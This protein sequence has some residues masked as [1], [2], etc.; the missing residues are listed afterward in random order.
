MENNQK[1]EEHSAPSETPLSEPQASTD[2]VAPTPNPAP[3]NPEPAAHKNSAG[4][5][6]LQWLTYAFWGWSILSSYILVWTLSSYFIGDNSGLGE[7]TA[8]VVAAALVLLPVAFVTDLFY[9]RIEPAKKTG[10][11]SIVMV[12]HAV[13]FA[14]FAIGNLIGAIFAVLSYFISESSASDITVSLVSS[15]VGVFLYFIVFIRTLNPQKLGSK[16]SFVHAILQLVFVLIIVI[17]SFVGPISEGRRAR[18][19]RIIERGLPEVSRS[20]NDYLADNGELPEDLDDLSPTNS[21]AKKLIEDDLVEYEPNAKSPGPE[22]ESTYSSTDPTIFHYYELCVEYV[23]ESSYYSASSRP[24]TT[25]SEYETYLYISSHPEGEVCYKQK[26]S[27]S[28]QLY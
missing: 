5:I 22:R 4:Q 27:V 10:A 19:D 20:V 21:D 2:Q 12:I 6:V 8:Y 16:L 7:F 28:G 26:A 14:L 23:A 24:N 9:R 3:T 13:L 11:A 1:E 15:L 25:N 18:A 17:M